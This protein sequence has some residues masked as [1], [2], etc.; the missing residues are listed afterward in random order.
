ML[1]YK[2]EYCMAVDNYSVGF[3]LDWLLFGKLLTIKYINS[4]VSIL[5]G[6]LISWCVDLHLY[7]F[8]RL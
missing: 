4:S 1:K 5:V 7:V 6:G 3:Y 8:Y 2:N